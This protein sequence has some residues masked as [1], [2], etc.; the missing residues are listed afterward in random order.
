MRPILAILAKHPDAWKQ[1]YGDPLSPSQSLSAS[2]VGDR[3]RRSIVLPQQG[4]RIA[5]KG[6]LDG[7]WAGVRSAREACRML[8]RRDRTR[9]RML[10]TTEAENTA[11]TAAETPLA[12]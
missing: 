9:Q 2:L 4:M 10:V 1:T 8:A 3:Q 5:P 12:P 6:R 7:R 11:I